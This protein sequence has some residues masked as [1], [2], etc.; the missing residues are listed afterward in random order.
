MDIEIIC[1]YQCEVGENPLWH[2]GEKK[3]YWVDIPTGRLFWYDPATGQHQQINLGRVVGGFTFQSDGSLLMFMDGTEVAV[4]RDGKFEKT[5]VKEIP[6]EKHKR[7]NDVI[8]DPKGRVFCGS[9]L[10]HTKLDDTFY[11][12]DTGGK[13]T[14]LFDEIGIS[15][16]MGFSPDGKKFYFTDSLRDTI[17]VFDYDE[18]TGEISNRQTLVEILPH[19]SNCPDGMTVDADGNIWSAMA[20]GGCLVKYSAEGKELER[21][22]MPCGFVTSLSFGGDDFSDA[23]VTTGTA[24]GT[25]PEWGGA[26]AGALLRV[27]GLGVKGKPEFY[28]RVGL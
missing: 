6:E 19:E 9:Y 8:A 27:R 13:I 20:M 22:K 26:K 4:W 5:I 18:S 7:F 16:G 23:Y 3:F 11:L 12:L 2:P 15:N 25:G 14:K 1:N 10:D 17:Y 24:L 28:S 21:I